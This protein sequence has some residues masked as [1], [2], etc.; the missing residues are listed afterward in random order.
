MGK[1]VDWP[2]GRQIAVVQAILD[3]FSALDGFE[4][5]LTVSIKV[6]GVQEPITVSQD[7][8]VNIPDGFGALTHSIRLDIQAVQSEWSEPTPA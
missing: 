4:A 7:G 8:G 3:G 6:D 5:D 2:G 1:R